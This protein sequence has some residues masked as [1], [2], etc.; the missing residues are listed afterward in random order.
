MRTRGKAAW[1]HTKSDKVIQRIRR[2]D[3][4]KHQEWTVAQSH[5]V[6]KKAK[7]LTKELARFLW[8]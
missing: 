1:L 8:P 3:R 4:R 5:G 6:A 7:L 2:T